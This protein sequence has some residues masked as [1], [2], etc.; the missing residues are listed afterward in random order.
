MRKLSEQGRLINLT[1]TAT[2][3]EAGFVSLTPP[4]GSTF[5][6]TDGFFSTGSGDADI[7]IDL[8]SGGVIIDSVAADA[9]QTNNGAFHIDF[10]QLIGNG[11]RTIQ[12]NT[13]YSGAGAQ[14]T[15]AG[16]SGYLDN[17]D[18]AK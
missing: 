17:T 14:T 10:N 11:T 3:T 12:M 4:N 8:V 1:G 5:F 13:T 6:Y 9:N 7:Q 2:G 16:F 15:T 18:T